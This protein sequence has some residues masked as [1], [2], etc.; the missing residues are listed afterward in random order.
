MTIAEF[1]HMEPSI[2]RTLLLQ[3]CGS[4][5]WI[6]KM[7]KM[8]PVEDLIDLFEDA[9]EKWYECNEA[10]WKEAFS[11]HPKIGDMDALR[12]KF[13]GDLFAG[14]EQSSINQAS[15]KSLTLLAEANKRYE[16]KFGYIFIVCASGKSADEMIDILNSRLQNAPGE[17]IKIAMD[18][19]N[20]I[21][22]LRLEKI[23]EI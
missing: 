14:D 21:T 8:P 19:Q 10:D 12:K 5:A 18:E 9:E 17:E 2:K 16:E 13:S 20:K 7:L 3:C 1:D 15:E 11:H 6:D 22:K 4:S 23:F